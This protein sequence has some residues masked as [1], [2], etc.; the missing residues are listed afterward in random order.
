M[1]HVLIHFDT[2]VTF[3]AGFAQ[4]AEGDVT[5]NTSG[6]LC[7]GTNEL[8]AYNTSTCPEDPND[9]RILLPP[10]YKQRTVYPLLWDILSKR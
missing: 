5:P 6:S 7:N 9:V 2:Q 3:V 1:M 4:S 8:C 10:G